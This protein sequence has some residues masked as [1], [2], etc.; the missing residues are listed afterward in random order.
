MPAVK[1]NCSCALNAVIMQ[2]RTVPICYS[3]LS[4][5]FEMLEYPGYLNTW[6]LFW[7]DVKLIT[8]PDVVCTAAFPQEEDPTGAKT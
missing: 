4:R 3:N 1:H 8:I 5:V 6:L 2:L 7:T